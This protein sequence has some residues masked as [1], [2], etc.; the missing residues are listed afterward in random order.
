MEWDAP[1]VSPLYSTS[2]TTLKTQQRCLCPTWPGAGF[3]L[4]RPLEVGGP[5]QTGKVGAGN[6]QWWLQSALRP[7]QLSRGPR[8]S[9]SRS[10]SLPAAAPTASRDWASHRQASG[11]R[12]KAGLGPCPPSHRGTHSSSSHTSSHGSKALRP[13]NTRQVRDGPE[14]P[15]L[16]HSP[17]HP[18]RV[19]PGTQKMLHMTKGLLSRCPSRDA[20][21]SGVHGTS[22]QGHGQQ[23]WGHRPHL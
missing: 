17:P 1:F 8:G 10:P 6:T 12:A 22:P 19:A 9:G 11:D 21:K 3:H 23:L 2:S 14:T 20:S 7:W 15:A 13:Y 16:A 4:P 5:E 18:V